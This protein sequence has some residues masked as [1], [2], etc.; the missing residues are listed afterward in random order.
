M[1]L[2][3]HCLIVNC[4]LEAQ[5]LFFFFEDQCTKIQHKPFW[6]KMKT[7]SH[8]LPGS[9]LSLL[10]LMHQDIFFSIFS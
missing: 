5:M 1:T 4:S 6:N 2:K 9:F 8:K 10:Y 7:M 3:T